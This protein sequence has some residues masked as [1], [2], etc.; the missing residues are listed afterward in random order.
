MQADVGFW[1][2]S[3]RAMLL[4][5][6]RPRSGAEPEPAIRVAK[7]H[8][9][10]LLFSYVRGKDDLYKRVFDLL[11]LSRHLRAGWSGGSLGRLP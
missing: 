3:K 6:P 11:A 10:I 1:A 2:A 7:S 4:R 8:S 9:E 5:K